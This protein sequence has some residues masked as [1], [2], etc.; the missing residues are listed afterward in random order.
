[1]R[2]VVLLVIA[3]PLAHWAHGASRHNTILDQIAV[4]KFDA[5]AVPGIQCSVSAYD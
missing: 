5:I 2:F 3:F 1:M 4:S